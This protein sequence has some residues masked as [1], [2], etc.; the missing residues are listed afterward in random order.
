MLKSGEYEFKCIRIAGLF[1]DWEYGK[2]RI[3]EIEQN[4]SPGCKM[5]ITMEFGETRFSDRV[6]TVRETIVLDA[7]GNERLR[8][9]GEVPNLDHIEPESEIRAES[10]VQSDAHSETESEVQP[11]ETSPEDSVQTQNAILIKEY[12]QSV[13]CF[14]EE[15]LRSL[16]HQYSQLKDKSVDLDVKPIVEFLHD[17]LKATYEEIGVLIK[18]RPSLLELSDLNELN[19]FV[20]IFLTDLGVSCSQLMRFFEEGQGKPSLSLGTKL[21]KRIESL[22]KITKLNNLEVGRLLTGNGASISS[23]ENKYYKRFENLKTQLDVKNDEC[24]NMVLKY[25]N[26]LTR[27]ETNISEKVSYLTLEQNRSVEE[28]AK[29]LFCLTFSLEEKIKKRFDLLQRLRLEPMSY[30]LRE[31]IESNED[32]FIMMLVKD[33]M[34]RKECQEKNVDVDEVSPKSKA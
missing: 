20:S 10:D 15:D 18:K 19:L 11:E 33:I 12:F 26:I 7:N 28:I 24:S 5:Q 8:T 34:K 25:P 23:S 2:N 17:K 14:N 6:K 27:L 30:K 31:I 22:K 9:F 32:K 1:V 16:F 4:P 21:R 29:H 3:L 13:L